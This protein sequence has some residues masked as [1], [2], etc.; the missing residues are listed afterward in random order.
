M[1][2]AEFSEIWADFARSVCNDD[3]SVN[4]VDEYNHCAFSREFAKETAFVEM[5]Q[6]I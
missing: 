2:L 4:W 3:N 1:Y 6:F 5:H